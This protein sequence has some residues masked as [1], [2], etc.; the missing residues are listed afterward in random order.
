MEKKGVKIIKSECHYGKIKEV[1]IR[2]G[3]VKEKDCVDIIFEVNVYQH[4]NINGEYTKTYPFDANKKSELYSL[5]VNLTGI[6]YVTEREN[7][8]TYKDELINKICKLEMATY[9][10][11]ID[12]ST[13][14]DIKEVTSK[15]TAL[16][17]EDALGK[18]GFLGRYC[19]IKNMG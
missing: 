2:Y 6:D 11:K 13:W 7:F 12:K 19:Q 14:W 9:Y 17:F 1:K 18:L 5:F 15:L 8:I 16:R 3:D 10:R 4:I